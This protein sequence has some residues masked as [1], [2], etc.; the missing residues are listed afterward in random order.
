MGISDAEAAGLIE[1]FE[2]LNGPS[3]KRQLELAL[4]HV[5]PEMRERIERCLDDPIPPIFG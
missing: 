3:Q 5:S 4:S 1:A 2:R